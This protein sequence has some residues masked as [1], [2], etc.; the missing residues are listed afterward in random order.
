MCHAPY[1]SKMGGISSQDT[2]QAVVTIAESSVRVG[3]HAWPPPP[4]RAAPGPT[5]VREAVS[6]VCGRERPLQRFER[7]LG[8]T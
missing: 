6:R 5:H 2:F 1:N 8:F 7:R 3:V 4:L